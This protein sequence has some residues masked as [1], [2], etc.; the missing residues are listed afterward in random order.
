MADVT[1]ISTA[2]LIRELSSREGVDGSEV[3]T[4]R[5]YNYKPPKDGYLF[6]VPTNAKPHQET[7]KERFQRILLERYEAG[8]DEAGM[9]LLALLTGGKAN[10]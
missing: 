7:V 2:D 5:E 6:I 9:M 4:G 10:G 3:E 1:A 8:N